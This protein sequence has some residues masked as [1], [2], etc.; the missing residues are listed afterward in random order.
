MSDVSQDTFDSVKYP[1]Q[2]PV[3]EAFREFSSDQLPEK[4]RIAEAAIAKRLV[5]L[6]GATDQ[7]E[8]QALHDAQNT[9]AVLKRQR[10][11]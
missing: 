9:L 5:E 7:E 6:N 1:W 2:S 3:L 4:I 8:T 10:R 11:E